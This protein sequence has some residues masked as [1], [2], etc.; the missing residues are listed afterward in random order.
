MI[1]SHYGLAGR[2]R[3]RFRIG[4]GTWRRSAVRS[5]CVAR[6]DLHVAL[7]GEHLMSG[8]CPFPPKAKVERRL[9]DPELTN[10]EVRQPPWKYGIEVERF[11]GRIGL[12]P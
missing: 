8:D 5:G 1:S 6:F 4:T 3:P 9:A 2:A 11:M 7:P 12:K 10:R